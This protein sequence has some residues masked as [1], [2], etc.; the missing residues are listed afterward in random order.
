MNK[1]KEYKKYLKSLKCKACQGEGYHLINDTLD[2]EVKCYFCKGSG[3]RIEVHHV[4]NYLKRII[5]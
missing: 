1:Y 4:I 3:F 5:R 2:F